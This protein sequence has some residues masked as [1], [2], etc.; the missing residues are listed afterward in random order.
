MGPIVDWNQY[1]Y[2]C[3]YNG[4]CIEQPRSG[5]ALKLGLGKGDLVTLDQFRPRNYAYR[6]E[7]LKLKLV[8]K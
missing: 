1:D 4:I 3:A 8:P 6:G 7:K 5:L 2:K